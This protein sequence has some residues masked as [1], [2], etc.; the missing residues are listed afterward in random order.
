MILQEVFK[1][2]LLKLLDTYWFSPGPLGPS[3]FPG[4]SGLFSLLLDEAT[5]QSVSQCL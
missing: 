5:G 1:I 3:G 2:L 4:S